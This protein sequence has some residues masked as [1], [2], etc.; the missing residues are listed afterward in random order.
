MLEKYFSPPAPHI[1]ITLKY[2][3][4]FYYLLFHQKKG[5]KNFTIIISI[6]TKVV[7]KHPFFL[8]TRCFTMHSYNELI[9]RCR[10]NY[11]NYLYQ[12]LPYSLQRKK[13]QITQTNPEKTQVLIVNGH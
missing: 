7:K 4:V 11:V 6:Q 5:T 13:P 3:Q 10:H 8:H 1:K 9:L 2:A 12:T